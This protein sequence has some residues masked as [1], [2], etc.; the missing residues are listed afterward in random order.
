MLSD[1]EREAFTAIERRLTDVDPH[2]A[3]WV[4]PGERAAR[5]LLVWLTHILVV[6]GSLA[7]MLVTFDAVSPGPA[8]FFAAVIGASLGLMRQLSARQHHGRGS[9]PAG[10]HGSS[11]WQGPRVGPP[12]Q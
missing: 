12:E 9:G 5:P 4:V 7:A 6:V 10:A 2:R 3:W 1:H 8:L 11:P